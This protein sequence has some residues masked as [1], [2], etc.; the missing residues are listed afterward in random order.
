MKLDSKLAAGT[1]ILHPPFEGRVQDVKNGLE[2]NRARQ[3]LVL[4]FFKLANFIKK[5]KNKI[6]GWQRNDIPLFRLGIER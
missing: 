3:K 6:D 4:L 1:D 5:L 2:Q